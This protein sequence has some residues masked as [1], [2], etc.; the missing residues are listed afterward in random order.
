MKRKKG[1]Y[2]WR[3]KSKTTFKLHVFFFVNYIERI[4]NTVRRAIAVAEVRG[5]GGGINSTPA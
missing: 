2:A 4:T 3:T 5:G 1:K